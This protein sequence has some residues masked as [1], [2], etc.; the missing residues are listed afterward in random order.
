VTSDATGAFSI[1]NVTPPYDVT[2]SNTTAN[3]AHVFVGLTSTS[4]TLFPYGAVAGTTL[5]A[6]SATMNGTITTGT[7]IDST[8]PVEVCVEGL[9]EVV[10]G[11][12]TLTSSNTYS[13]TANWAST[14]NV[15]V[16]VHAL[17]MVLPSAGAMPSGY[18]GYAAYTGSTT[19][20]PGSTYSQNVTLGAAPSTAA[21]SGTITAPSGLASGG[22]LVFL[23]LTSRFTIPIGNVSLAGTSTAYSATVPAMSGASYQLVALGSATGI[24]SGKWQ[25]SV[26]AGSGRDLTLAAAPTVASPPSSAGPGDTFS[27]GNTGGAPLTVVFFPATAGAG[28]VLAVTTSGTSVTMPNTLPVASSTVYHW[29][30][31]VNP[32]ESLDQATGDWIGGYYSLLSTAGAGLASDGGFAA[33]TGPF[34]FTVP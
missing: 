10:V 32:G 12:Q 17:Q 5:P 13:I 19:M 30:A 3:W 7:T 31:I 11:C 21:L 33:N 16:K 14:A 1:D 27:V 20:V 4:P 2:V 23:R 9:S 6:S 24:M 8:H 18:A 34:S 29:G 25:T 26:A 22:V 15:S 28:P